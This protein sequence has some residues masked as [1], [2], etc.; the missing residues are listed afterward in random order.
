MNWNSLTLDEFQ[1]SLASKSATPGGGTASAVALGQSAA[2]VAM[3]SRLTI[4]NE[5]WQDGW[6]H[7]QS[8]LETASEVME[9][10]NRLAIED[11]QAFD[12]VMS[13]FKLPKTTEVETGLRKES[14]RK[15]TL[16][17]AEVPYKTASLAIKLLDRMEPL[18]KS[19]NA[20]AVSDVG[21]ACLLATAGCT[22]A[23]FNVEINLNS[24][25]ADLGSDMRNNIEEI[26]EQCREL[27]KIIMHNVKS[28]L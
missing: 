13:A 15:A 19:C 3:V 17:A 12:E 7:S 18:S 25:P 14:I 8:A 2:L 26:N 23:L 27:S 5:K 28:R 9:S 16:L 11:S 21:V 20:N 1:S 6:N 24:L 22:G 10:S 4:G